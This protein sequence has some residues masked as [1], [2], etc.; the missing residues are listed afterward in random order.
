MR[1]TETGK[2]GKSII[3]E[4][5][6]V[7]TN[8]DVCCFCTDIIWNDEGEPYRLEYPHLAPGHNV[9]C[10]TIDYEMKVCQ[11]SVCVL[12]VV[13]PT[14]TNTTTEPDIVMGVSHTRGMRGRMR[15]VLPLQPTE[16]HQ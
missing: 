3:T 4:N 15:H 10:E 9:P 2:V 1:D 13:A 14:Q 5:T 11:K 16:H 12:T 6:K 8:H 7:H